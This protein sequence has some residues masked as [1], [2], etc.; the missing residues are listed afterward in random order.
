MYFPCMNL[1]LHIILVIIAYLAHFS[2]DFLAIRFILWKLIIRKC[3]L[4]N[5][6]KKTKKISMIMESSVNRKQVPKH[7]LT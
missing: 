2:I 3:A 4:L 7:L 1:C 6:D 5:I